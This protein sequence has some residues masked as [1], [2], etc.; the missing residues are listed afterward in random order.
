[1]Y[2]RTGKLQ[3]LYTELA[4]EK[5]VAKARLLTTI[6]DSEDL[7]VRGAGVKVDCGRKV[8]TPGTIKVA[9]SRLKMQDITGITNQGNEGLCTTLK[10]YTYSSKKDQRAMIVD[11]V[12]ESEETYQGKG[13]VPDGKY[14]KED[15]ITK[16]LSTCQRRHSILWLI[17]YNFPL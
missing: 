9:K 1:M 12:R 2:S 14:Q 16:T 11:T 5:K 10:K 3:L 13:Q 8:D 4:E 7:Y 6:E 15:W 17:Q